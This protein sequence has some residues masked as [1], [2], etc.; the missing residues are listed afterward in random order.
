[1]VLWV[2]D[3][4]FPF[5]SVTIDALQRFRSQSWEQNLYDLQK[6]IQQQ[7]ENPFL[8]FLLHVFIYMQGSSLG[9]I[10][11]GIAVRITWNAVP[12]NCLLELLLITPQYAVYCRYKQVK[13][14][15]RDR[16]LHAGP[17]RAAAGFLATAEGDDQGQACWLQASLRGPDCQAHGSAPVSCS[18]TQPCAVAS[19]NTFIFFPSFFGI[20]S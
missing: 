16:H 17:M 5:M 10:Y 15:H 4:F 1:M 19:R 20:G 7:R 8:F 14:A 3:F 11:K 9:N 12:G 13:A 18:C 6:I 2:F